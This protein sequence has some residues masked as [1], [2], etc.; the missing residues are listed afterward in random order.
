M[1]GQL[2][3]RIWQENGKVV[4]CSRRHLQVTAGHRRRGQLMQLPVLGECAAIRSRMMG[5]RVVCCVRGSFGPGA[6]LRW[7]GLRHRYVI[8]ARKADDCDAVVPGPWIS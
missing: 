3:T 4:S 7:V 6:A 5:W 8:T 2:G 1:P